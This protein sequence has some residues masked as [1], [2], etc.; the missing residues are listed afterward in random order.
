MRSRRRDRA[1][2]ASVRGATR[3]RSIGEVTVVA[4]TSANPDPKDVLE[5][6]IVDG[7]RGFLTKPRVVLDGRVVRLRRDD[8][9]LRGHG[10]AASFVFTRA[11]VGDRFG[12][13]DYDGVVIIRTAPCGAGQ[14]LGECLGVPI[15]LRPTP[16]LDVVAEWTQ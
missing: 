9:R 11:E 6:L 2:A 12:P 7:P 3:C 8:P 4:T 5:G 1:G 15:P 13:G 16:I 10:V 14:R